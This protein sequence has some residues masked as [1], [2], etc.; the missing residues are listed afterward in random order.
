MT[1]YRTMLA[2]PASEGHVCPVC[3]GPTEGIHVAG[4]GVE[5]A[6]QCGPKCAYQCG[7]KCREVFRLAVRAHIHRR[8]C[9]G[10]PFCDMGRSR[11]R[12]Y[13]AID[14]MPEPAT[15]GDSRLA[16]AVTA[17]TEVSQQLRQEHAS[18][19]E[20]RERRRPAPVASK[21]LP[22]DAHPRRVGSLAGFRRSKGH[23]VA[24]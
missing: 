17:M 19:Q 3:Q 23:E 21:D 13:V 6:Y 12:R 15:G 8:C 16:Q 9:D 22:A 7:P 10:P 11:R 4:D 2:R 1:D 24:R 5:R 20:W 14:P 18:R